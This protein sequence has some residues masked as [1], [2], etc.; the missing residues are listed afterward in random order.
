MNKP[1]EIIDPCRLRALPSLELE[2]DL[3]PSIE[4]KLQK[5]NKPS[6][7]RGTK[8]ILLA[9]SAL[10]AVIILQQMN[11]VD[12][13]NKPE[14]LQVAGESTVALEN[15]RQNQLKRLLTMS[16]TLE[17]RIYSPQLQNGPLSA[18]EA[19]MIA[20]LEDMIAVVDRQLAQHTADPELWYRR[21]A[22]LTN[23]AGIYQ[24]R[25][26]RDFSQ[27]VAL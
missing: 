27:Y 10:L 17:N 14:Q 15:D 25:R 8:I 5:A 24:Q 12:V 20:E 3:W 13:V 23:L 19:V 11:M 26:T 16:Q 1:I 18:N 22:L 6:A 7:F 4:A 2:D 21:V 9:A